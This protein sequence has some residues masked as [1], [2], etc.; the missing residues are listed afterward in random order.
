M[1]LFKY[2]LENAD[3]ELILENFVGDVINKI[4]V[5]AI[6]LFLLRVRAVEVYFGIK[7]N[8]IFIKYNEKNRI[9]YRIDENTDMCIK[10]EDGI[11]N[12]YVNKLESKKNNVYLYNKF[13]GYKLLGFYKDNSILNLTLKTNGTYVDLASEYFAIRLLTWLG[14]ERQL[15]HFL[16]NEISLKKYDF[17][18]Y[19]DKVDIDISLFKELEGFGI[20]FGTSKLFKKETKIDDYDDLDILINK[21]SDKY[22]YKFNIEHL[23]FSSNELESFGVKKHSGLFAHKIG[24]K[25]I[26]IAFNT[27]INQNKTR[28]LFLKLM[29]YEIFD[30]F[31][32]GDYLKI[33]LGAEKDEI[34]FAAS[35]FAIELVV[36]SDMTYYTIW[37]SYEEQEKIKKFTDYDLIDLEKLLFKRI[38]RGERIDL[39]KELSYLREHKKEYKE[40]KGKKDNGK[41]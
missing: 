16:N 4:T 1:D 34:D 28:F 23:D 8:F 5:I 30:S 33:N 20:V 31:N 2:F 21:I 32:V 29:G 13:L 41:V 15:N 17:N 24:E 40:M 37:R 18:S 36:N 27:N 26:Y 6:N 14:N 35:F 22:G 7:S 9:K 38:P 3:D 10:H 39:H 11:Y 19:P 25:E 12:I